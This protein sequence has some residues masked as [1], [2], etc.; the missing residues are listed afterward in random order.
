MAEGQT[1][2]AL[3][4]KVA[5]MKA[6]K[7]RRLE[8]ND[9]SPVAKKTSIKQNANG[10]IR[11]E[12]LSWSEVAM[13]DRLED[14]EGFYGLEEI[15]D[16]DVVRD[17]KTGSFA[18]RKIGQRPDED[19]EHDG[20]DPA[21]TDHDD[22]EWDGFDDDAPNNV[23]GILKTSASDLADKATAKKKTKA[24][25]KKAEKQ[26]AD[27]KKSKPVLNSNSA[28]S[29][30]L[31]AGLQAETADE[32]ADVSLWQPLELSPDTLASLARLKFSKP[33]PI[34]SAAI[35]E[36]LAGHDVIG[37][38]STGSGKTMAFGIPIFETFLELRSQRQ[39]GPDDVEPKRAPLA[40]ILS[41]T[42]ELAHQLDAHFTALCSGLPSKPPSI[43]TLTGGLSLQKQQRLLKT[44]DIVIG[45]PGRLWEVISEGH[46]IMKWL[47]QIRYL[48]VDEADRLLSQGHFKEVEEI[49]NALDRK[50]NPEDGDPDDGPVTDAPSDESQRQTLVFS[51][52]FHKGLQQKLAGKGLPGGSGA[53]GKADD[54][55]YLLK[56]LNF[57]D[58]KPKY[59]DVNPKGQMATGLKE[60]LVECGGTE[61]VREIML[62][63]SAGSNSIP[64]PLP[65]L[66]LVATSRRTR[67]RLYKLHQRRQTSHTFSAKP[68]SPSP[69]PTL[70]NAAE[71]ASAL[72]RAILRTI[73]YRLHTGLHRRRSARARY[74]KCTARRALPPA[75]C[76][77]HV[78]APLWPHS[79]R[80]RNG[81][82]HP[83]LRSRRSSG[84]AA[85]GGKSAREFCSC[86]GQVWRR[87]G[88]QWLFHPQSGYRPQGGGEAEAEGIAREAA[89]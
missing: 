73:K 60:G 14:L 54:M 30:D 74:P 70:A 79:A 38:A 83:D 42:R 52:T 39:S 78:R 11:Q 58:E 9:E 55:E 2:R 32:T 80:R 88:A 17:E 27:K 20:N 13:P 15:E 8:N 48:V 82:Q 85:I 86:D 7:R 53:A 21:T 43:A 24:E 18:F 64:G 89:C 41:P 46:G 66:A 23:P 22:E 50:D 75:A 35:P 28:A 10:N 62:G 65:V 26:K 76:S 57:R 6:R 68:T 69:A 87:G 4:A 25:K 56:K 47:K 72:H 16:V 63:L 37:K 61:K 81:L 34:Q 59:I 49:L 29:T 44:A 12:E 31:F 1:K 84:R 3:P 33:T 5:A 36:I 45:T 19:E 77:R 67:P 51:A 40:L 71:S